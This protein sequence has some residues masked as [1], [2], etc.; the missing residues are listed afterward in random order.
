[1]CPLLRSSFTFFW[2]VFSD[3]ST[4]KNKVTTFFRNLYT[5]DAV[6]FPRRRKTWGRKKKE[7]FWRRLHYTWDRSEIYIK[8]YSEIL[9]GINNLGDGGIQKRTIL[10][11]KLRSAR[12]L[13]GCGL[14]SCDSH[15]K[16][17]GGN[18]TGR[19]I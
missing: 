14:F 6:S 15:R 11:R 12:C 4:A 1:M 7:L 9:K 19:P 5:S 17:R 10:E 13:L 18:K 16:Q 2:F 3:T 8:M